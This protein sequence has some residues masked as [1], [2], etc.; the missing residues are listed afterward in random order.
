MCISTVMTRGDLFALPCGHKFYIGNDDEETLEGV[1]IAQHE[2][3]SY[4]IIIADFAELGED[5]EGILI[6]HE[7]LTVDGTFAF[8]PIALSNFGNELRLCCEGNYE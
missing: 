3:T 1:K 4:Q 6:R 8:I 7:D 5:G 2:G